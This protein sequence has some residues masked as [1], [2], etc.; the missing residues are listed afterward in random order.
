M[1]FV[2]RL[3]EALEAWGYP[4][5]VDWEGIAPTEEWK[6][7][8][9]RAIVGARAVVF[10]IS[11]HSAESAMCAEEAGYTA[12][13]G[14]RVLPVVRAEV[15][16]AGLPGPV[17]AH[18]WVWLR[19]EDGFEEGLEKLRRA[20][21]TDPAWAAEHTRLLVRADEWERAGRDR[22]LTLRG[23]KLSRAERWLT[24]AKARAI[25]GR[26]SSTPTSSSPVAGLAPAPS[27]S[28]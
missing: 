20:L 23:T 15:D 3:A 18:Q 11:P 16:P 22:S 24:E 6:Q 4:C 17:A 10:V 26:V 27:A 14:K 2:R 28:A 7:A 25:H 5:W 19:E 9:R 13:F 21:D 1:E 12:E 8:I